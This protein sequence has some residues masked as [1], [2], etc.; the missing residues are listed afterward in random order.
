MAALS[1]TLLRLTKSPFAVQLQLFALR[2]C[3]LLW[4]RI[5]FIPPY[6]R[7]TVLNLTPD[8]R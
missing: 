7:S 8:T 6:C 4:S 3:P 1:P 2:G 5:T